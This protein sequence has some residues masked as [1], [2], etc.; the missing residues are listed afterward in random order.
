MTQHPIETTVVNGAQVNKST[1]REEIKQYPREFGTAAAFRLHGLPNTPN[2]LIAGTLYKYD[3]A[4][5]T[6]PDNGTT[7]VL[8]ASSRRFKR[9]AASVLGSTL[10]TASSVA[11]TNA[12]TCNTDGMATLSATPQL[13]W[14]VFV[15][16]NT[17][18]MTIGFDG[19][20]SVALK[21]PLG[22]ALASDEVLAGPPYLLRVTATDARIMFSGATW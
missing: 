16:N 2:A 7:C 9:Q 1:F 8:D 6:T 3:A 15:N 21:S 11:G 5:L 19:A 20:A 4:D 22:N 18:A 14:I 17:G 12:V 10:F 13:I